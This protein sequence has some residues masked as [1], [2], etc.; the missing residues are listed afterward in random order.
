MK[1]K[2][3][4]RIGSLP[5]VVESDP[6]VPGVDVRN[7]ILKIIFPVSGSRSESDQTFVRY[8]Y[9]QSVPL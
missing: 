7:Q 6:E 5:N 2:G 8:Y 9:V 3:N 1:V 4:N